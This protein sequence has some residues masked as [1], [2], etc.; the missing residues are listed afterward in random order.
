MTTDQGWTTTETAGWPLRE[1]FH[2][3]EDRQPTEV[4]QAELT[5]AP[6]RVGPPFPS[7]AT[8]TLAT[9]TT[10]PGDEHHDPTGS[11]LPLYDTGP[12]VRDVKLSTNFTVGEL[13]R[14]GGR[15]A[16]K[17]RISPDLVRLL[18][19]I[20]DRVNPRPVIVT[21]GY[22][23]FTRNTAVY[24]RRR[25]TPT[26]SQHSAGRAADIR[27]PGMTGLD[28]AKTAIDVWGPTV[29]VGIARDYAHIDVRGQ[30]KQWTY[31]KKGDTMRGQPANAQAIAEIRA[32]RRAA[33][34][35]RPPTNNQ[36]IPLDN[37][38]N[39]FGYPQGEEIEG[40]GFTSPDLKNEEAYAIDE[41]YA[42]PERDE[43][44]D[45]FFAGHPQPTTYETV[46][47]PGTPAFYE[48][49]ST[50]TSGG[51]AFGPHGGA[52]RPAS[53]SPV[54]TD[55]ELLSEAEGF[56]DDAAHAYRKAVELV[57]RVAG[58]VTA[59]TLAELWKNHPTILD[60]EN[61]P[62]RNSAGASS[63]P[64]QCVVRLGLSLTR[65]GISL[66][67]YPGKFCDFGHGR[68]HPIRVNDMRLWL[69]TTASF[70]AGRTEISTRPARGKQKT[71][72]DFDS[73]PGIVAF[74]DF[75][76]PENSPYLTGDHI[77]LWD[78]TQLALGNNDYF[79]RSRE[80]WFWP[81][82]P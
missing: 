58:A 73:R 54:Y 32:Y 47:R 9:G 26:K 14:S 53:L 24:A 62:C 74:L 52:D 29:A 3:N 2:H 46:D 70:S 63:Y 81:L 78:G 12:A 59:P 15:Y 21:S 51:Q 56:F 13:V 34:S 30:G 20:R 66:A 69:H 48:R 80:L 50:P 44:E 16:A 45:E 4:P 60:K 22:R 7:G 37:Y 33:E 61:A 77:D 79:E 55:V 57:R 19:G 64:N 75:Y 8:L 25:S 39:D 41:D 36:E 28:I 76:A 65:C 27:V 43:L 40:S 17:A 49:P 11:D 5:T 71:S 10:G 38:T 23:S 68:E 18:Q 31:F 35:R 72:G 67:T 1:V 82:R 6:G 42:D